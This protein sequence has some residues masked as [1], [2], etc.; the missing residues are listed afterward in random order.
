VLIAPIAQLSQKGKTTMMDPVSFQRIAEIRQHEYQAIANYERNS[1]PLHL[2][3]AEI[4][5]KVIAR[6]TA[7]ND[8]A[9][10]Q[11]ARDLTE[12]CVEC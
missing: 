11:T 4:V 1:K 2:G 10:T 3:I 12:A 9:P 5:N 8:T 6:F 7:V